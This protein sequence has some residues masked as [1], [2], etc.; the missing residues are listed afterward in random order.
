MKGST[1]IDAA[2]SELGILNTSVAPLIL[3]Q[4]WVNPNSHSI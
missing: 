1:N 4:R 3:T 2:V